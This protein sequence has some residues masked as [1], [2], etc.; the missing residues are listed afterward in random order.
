[1]EEEARHTEFQSEPLNERDS[2]AD[3]GVNGRE[4]L[5]LI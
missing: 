5:K 3:V 2:L 4:I 1:M